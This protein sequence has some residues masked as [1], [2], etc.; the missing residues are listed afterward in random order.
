MSEL[1][2]ANPGELATPTGT[3]PLAG[4]RQGDVSRLRGVDVLCREGRIAAIGPPRE[5]AHLAGAETE[6]FDARGGA[7]VPGFVDPH[8]HLPWAGS[9]A[10]EFAERLA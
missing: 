7:L 3:V 1:W 4:P 6:R 8:T 2:I 5:I 10:G 9:R